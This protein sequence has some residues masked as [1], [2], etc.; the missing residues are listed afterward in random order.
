MWLNKPLDNN[1]QIVY[2]LIM[3]K[4]AITANI[5]TVVTT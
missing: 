4:K 2:D 5:N 1:V 3:M